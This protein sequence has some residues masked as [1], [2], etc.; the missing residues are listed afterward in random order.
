MKLIDFEND[1]WSRDQLVLGLDEAGY[2]CL[3]GSMYI[4]GVLYPK[5]FNI[6]ESLIEVKDSKKLSESM[7]FS[8]AEQIKQYA[9]YYFIVKVDV[10]EINNGNPYWLRFTSIEKYI[11]NNISNFSL[12]TR[13]IYDGDRSVTGIP[14]VS[15]AVIKG[16]AKSFSI[17]SASI[18]AKTAKDAEMIEL[19]KVYPMY[20]FE[21][22][23]GYG[24]AQHITALQKHGLSE[25]HRRQYCSKYN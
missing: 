24:T 5:N 9:K 20:N 17:A 25:V 22:N 2:G 10:N 23:K 19:S 12:N 6:P 3:A 15:E 7:R 14:L 13:V 18:L 16:D 21:N 1:Y 11:N 8:L 4:G